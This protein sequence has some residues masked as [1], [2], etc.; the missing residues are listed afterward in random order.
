MN[1]PALR[2]LEPVRRI[3]LDRY[4]DR[5]QRALSNSADPSDKANSFVNTEGGSESVKAAPRVC[6]VPLHVFRTIHGV[7]MCLAY[8]MLFGAGIMFT[9]RSQDLQNCKNF[10][11][12]HDVKTGPGMVL[13]EHAG[14]LYMGG[15]NYTKPDL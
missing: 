11:A 7:S 6:G 12:P 1:S 14:A 15:S 9:R 10:Y 4:L 2:F 5:Y 8:S 3:P 13:F